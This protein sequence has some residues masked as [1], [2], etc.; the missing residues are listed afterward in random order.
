MV[1]VIWN[2]RGGFLV[3]G[4]WQPPPLICS[5]IHTCI[6]PW[7]QKTP[8]RPQ[9]SWCSDC[10][11][12]GLCGWLSVD[13]S[14][15]WVL[16]RIVQWPIWKA[17]AGNQR[18]RKDSET[19]YLFPWFPLCEIFLICDFQRKVIAALK[20]AAFVSFSLFYNLSLPCFSLAWPG[21]NTNSNKLLPFSHYS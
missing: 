16:F 15:F 14:A 6:I 8:L 21:A 12:A 9:K 2:F 20:E 19:E 1:Y 5:A 18:E 4:L 11:K 7:R 10:W 3:F 17:P 13:S